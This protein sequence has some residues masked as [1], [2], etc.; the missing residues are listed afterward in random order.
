MSSDK[1]HG[2]QEWQ[3]CAKCYFY[4]QE[5]IAEDPRTRREVAAPGCEN[6][7]SPWYGL[8]R[9]SKEGLLCIDFS[10]LTDS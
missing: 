10:P 8:H 9:G 7:E 2:L 4:S 1:R 6:P 5:V 3:C